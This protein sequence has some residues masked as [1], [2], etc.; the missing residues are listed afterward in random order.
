MEL[1]V[2]VRKGNAL[3]KL[4]KISEAI[5]EYEKALTIEPGNKSVQKDLDVLRKS[6]N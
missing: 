1:R 5:F 6:Y 3:T 4:K 2:C